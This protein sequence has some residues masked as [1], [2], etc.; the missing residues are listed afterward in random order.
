M[1]CERPISCIVY[2]RSIRRNGTDLHIE[3]KDQEKKNLKECTS[4]NRAR[5]A[6]FTLATAVKLRVNFYANNFTLK[7]LS[8]GTEGGV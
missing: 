1:S 2:R 7:V 6:Y 5:F 3:N 8:N 4:L